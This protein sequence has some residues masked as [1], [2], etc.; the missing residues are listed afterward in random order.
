[1]VR[2]IIHQNQEAILKNESLSE[3]VVVQ[4]IDILKE[5]N[6]DSKDYIKKGVES[7]LQE[8]LRLSSTF[9]TEELQ[10]RWLVE[11]WLK[12]VRK[13]SKS[14]LMLLKR[15]QECELDLEPDVY[16]LL[17]DINLKIKYH[18]D[19][20]IVSL[21]GL[22]IF[23]TKRPG[24]SYDDMKNSEKTQWNSNLMKHSDNHEYILKLKGWLSIL[25]E[26]DIYKV[27]RYIA[28]IVWLDYD[29]NYEFFKTKQYGDHNWK[30]TEAITLLKWFYVLTGIDG[31]VFLKIDWDQLIQFN[32]YPWSDCFRINYEHVS[33]IWSVK[34]LYA[35]VSQLDELLK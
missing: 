11:S 22:D 27:L 10:L 12:E 3:D 18:D 13:Y 33:A 16:N 17:T 20:N 2:I 23:A 35:N 7:L 21:E 32:I 34:P 26:W 8:S 28:K 25:S 4:I 9:D 15:I 29:I 30:W 5:P 19:I 24:I 31:A 6:S 1:M 14:T